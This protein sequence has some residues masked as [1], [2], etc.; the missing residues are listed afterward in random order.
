MLHLGDLMP[1]KLFFHQ[2]LVEPHPNA[3][4]VACSEGGIRLMGGHMPMITDPTAQF[5]LTW[6]T[7]QQHPKSPLRPY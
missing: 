1:R 2:T 6:Q 7:E 3:L 4:V 5:L